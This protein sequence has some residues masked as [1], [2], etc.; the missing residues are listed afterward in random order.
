[1]VNCIFC[2]INQGIVIASVVYEDEVSI[3]FMDI[4]PVTPGHVLVV[5]RL[6]AAGL[7][8]LP[9]KIGGH[10][11]II[12]QKIA[13]GLKNSEIRCEGTNFFLADGAVAFQTVFHVHLHVIPR[14]SGDG[15]RL[16]FGPDYHNLPK[17]QE[18]DRLAK[19]LKSG[20]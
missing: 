19:I 16:S 4:Q 15:F 9:E 8:D 2:K 18:L 13:A 6:H 7:S 10:L 11:F 14:F 12:G 3:A 17:R 1:M 20:L 5:P